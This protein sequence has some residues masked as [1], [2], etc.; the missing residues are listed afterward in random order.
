MTSAISGSAA[1]LSL[2]LNGFRDAEARLA[3]AA[4]IAAEGPTS[5]D[6]LAEAALLLAQA[7]AQQA[8]SA[9]ALQTSL[10][11]ERRVIDILA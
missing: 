10:D 11:N 2:A 6:G 1:S 9:N 4:K 7:K 8:A 5:S 3:A